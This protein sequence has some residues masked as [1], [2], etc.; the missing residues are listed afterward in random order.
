MSTPEPIR[1]A[2]L[3]MAAVWEASDREQPD[4]VLEGALEVGLPLPAL[5]AGVRLAGPGGDVVDVPHRVVHVLLRPGTVR[6]LD[7]AVPATELRNK[8]VV[9]QNDLFELPVRLR[10]QPGAERA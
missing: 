3:M 8:P 5:V 9:T 7:L 6:G 10:P 2:S 1:L 4:G